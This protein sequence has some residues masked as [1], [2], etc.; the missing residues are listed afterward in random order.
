MPITLR[1]NEELIKVVRQHVIFLIP[2]FFTWP[3]LII[4][5]FLIRYLANFNFFGYWSLAL[6]SSILI[7]VLI[8][9]YK[10]YI[11]KNNAMIITNQRVIKNEQF[12][13]F[14]KTVTELIYKDIL[15]IS[16]SKDGMNASIYDYGDLKIRTASENDIIFEKIADP[17]ETVEFINNIRQSGTLYQPAADNPGNV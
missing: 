11:W 8:I 4:V 13:F 3:L 16:Y 15:E 9:L 7:V 14:S 10:L 2:I 17:D 12:G 6:P 1:Q 5:M